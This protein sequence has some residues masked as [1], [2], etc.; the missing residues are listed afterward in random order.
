MVIAE[1]HMHVCIEGDLQ[2]MNSYNIISLCSKTNGSEFKQS[3]PKQLLDLM[4]FGK[5]TMAY[6]AY[7]Q[8][9]YWT[10]FC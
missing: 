6:C 9:H 7:L 8:I 1:N 2:Q 3:D 5:L 4:L 10:T